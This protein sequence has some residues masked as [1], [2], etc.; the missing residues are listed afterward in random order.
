M[1]LSGII[2]VNRMK[3]IKFLILILLI[4]L[5]C[6][7]KKT[8]EFCEGVSP[9]GEGINCGERFSTGEV[10]VIIKPESTFTGTKIE[11]DVYKKTKYKSEKI[12]SHS[13]QINPEK[14]DVHTNIYFYDEGEF[15]LEVLGQ[16]KE[17]IAEGSVNIIDVY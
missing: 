16:G 8:V 10:T 17:K 7:S 3:K 6:K 5:S 15:F 2:T 4:I 13:I 1:I 11:I 12:E 14:P 9:E